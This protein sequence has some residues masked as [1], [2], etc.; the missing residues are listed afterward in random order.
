[1]EIVPVSVTVV[2]PSVPVDV[3]NTAVVMCIVIRDTH[4][5]NIG[6]SISYNLFGGFVY[7]AP[8]QRFAYGLSEASVCRGVG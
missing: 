2:K 4:Y 3:S 7:L 6:V 8:E 5:K 1:M